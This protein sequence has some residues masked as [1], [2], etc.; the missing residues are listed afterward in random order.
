M[1]ICPNDTMSEANLIRITR[2]REYRE[3]FDQEFPQ[4]NLENYNWFVRNVMLDVTR[5]LMKMYVIG[6]DTSRYLIALSTYGK[7]LVSLVKQS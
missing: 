7:E 4:T 3:Q 6:Y 2:R 1:L 5:Y